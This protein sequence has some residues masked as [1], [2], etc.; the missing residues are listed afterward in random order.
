MSARIGERVND[1]RGNQKDG[2][3]EL[4]FGQVHESEEIPKESIGNQPLSLLIEP[5]RKELRSIATHQLMTGLDLDRKAETKLLLQVGFDV[6]AFVVGHR[7]H[8][9]K[10]SIAAE[11]QNFGHLGLGEP[12]ELD[13]TEGTHSRNNGAGATGLLIGTMETTTTAVST[14]SRATEEPTRAQQRPRLRWLIPLGGGLLSA[15]LIVIGTPHVAWYFRLALA[16]I[17]FT[18][19]SGQSAMYLWSKHSDQG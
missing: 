14:R 15:G 6:P 4:H 8:D 7:H 2:R 17:A 12:A 10:K 13:V 9:L 5:D 11:C 16:L 18:Y 19:I 1:L 3:A